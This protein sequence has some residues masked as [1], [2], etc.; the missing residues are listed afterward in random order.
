MWLRGVM[1]TGN[2]SVFGI[3]HEQILPPFGAPQVIYMDQA[4]HF[5]SDQVRKMCSDIGAHPCYAPVSHPESVGLLERMVQLVISMLRKWYADAPTAQAQNWGHALG[6]I[7]LAANTRFVKQY[8][9]TPAELMLGYLPRTKNLMPD[10]PPH[11]IVDFNG[12]PVDLRYMDRVIE[13]RAE[14]RMSMIT[15][16]A[17][18]ND[19][20]E[21]A[22]K[23]PPWTPPKAGD[24]V[25]EAEMKYRIDKGDKLKLR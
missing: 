16:H 19:R 2:A 11:N 7:A 23:K 14:Q 4:R 13:L 17:E 8:G 24:L 1:N 10:P 18:V 5:H 15:K 3:L 9:F 25:L 21:N 22:E 12:P 6:H 20:I